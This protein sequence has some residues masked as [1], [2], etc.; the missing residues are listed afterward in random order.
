VQHFPGIHKWLIGASLAASLG[1]CT[2]DFDLRDLNLAPLPSDFFSGPSWMTNV[3]N[4]GT[5]SNK[6]V[7]AEELIGP[8]GLCAGMAA[9]PPVVAADAPSPLDPVA[10]SPAGASGAPLPIEG[11]PGAAAPG[12]PVAGQPIVFSGVGLGM[13]EC[14][15]V[16]R[17][18]PV[19]APRVGTNDRGE[20]ALELT[21]IQGPRPGTY[22]FVAGR[23]ISME[24]VPE[25][26]A[27]E[28]PQKR[29]RTK[30]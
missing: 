13:T 12:A 29:R 23:L 8:D 18:G 22:R 24:R 7:T 4:Q 1:A 16:R 26:P 14:D 5:G 9:G 10:S 19:V 30:S 6:K 11:A 20:R 21:Y 15:V 17:L 3:S 2:G 25:P 28:K 27:A